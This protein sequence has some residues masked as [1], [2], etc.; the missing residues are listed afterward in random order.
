MATKIENLKLAKD[1]CNQMHECMGQFNDS[2]RNFTG[3][4][5]RDVEIQKGNIAE[6]TAV[7]NTMMDITKSLTSTAMKGGAEFD[8]AVVRAREFIKLHQVA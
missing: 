2:T 3:N 6:S 5:M 1:L 7:W 8:T 4:I